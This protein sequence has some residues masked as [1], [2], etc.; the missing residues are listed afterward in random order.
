MTR[1][2]HRQVLVLDAD[3]P[4]NV[5]RVAHVEQRPVP[6]RPGDTTT[7]VYEQRIRHAEWRDPE[8]TSVQARHHGARNIAGWRRIDVIAAL[9]ASSPRE[10]TQAHLAAANR[11]R[12]DHEIGV[13]GA[14]LGRRQ[15]EPVDGGA[16]ADLTTAQLDALRRFRQAMAAVGGPNSQSA[17]LLVWVVLDNWNITDLSADSGVSR[18]RMHGRLQAALEQLKDHYMPPAPP[19]RGREGS[20]AASGDLDGVTLPADRLGR[21]RPSGGAA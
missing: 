11:L 14:K 9:H 17:T 10:I 7:A 13:L 20:P 1:R 6:G 3:G 15:N 21:W 4:P 16:T 12:R 8:D 18:D 2:R 5:Q 19:R